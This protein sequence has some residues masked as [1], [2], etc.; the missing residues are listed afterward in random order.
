LL[1]RRSGKEWYVGA[2]TDW[3]PRE[4]FIDFSFLP[5][6]EYEMTFYRDGTN[7]HRFG[8]DYKKETT[9]IPPTGSIKIQLAPGGGWA[10]RI[11]P[12]K[13]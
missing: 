12:L 3:T 2:M 8:S 5:Q 7:A 6:G 10:A 13:K 11:L 4:L 1:A 9:T